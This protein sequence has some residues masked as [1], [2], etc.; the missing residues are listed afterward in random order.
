MNMKV[1]QLSEPFQHLLISSQLA[2]FKFHF[3]FSRLIDKIEGGSHYS[4]FIII[5]VA[6]FI[7]F[8]VNFFIIFVVGFFIII[9]LISLLVFTIIFFFSLFSSFSF[10]FST[11]F[12]FSHHHPYNKHNNIFFPSSPLPPFKCTSIR[13]IKLQ[14][15]HT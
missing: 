8:S 3:G 11:F 13:T 7:I 12:C 1:T 4:C 14:L 9:F 15:I 2:A 10:S 5:F 6:V